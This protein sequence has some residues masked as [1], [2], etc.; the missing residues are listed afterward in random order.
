[1]HRCPLRLAPPEGVEMKTD[2]T[3]TVARADRHAQ[4]T[5]VPHPHDWSGRIPASRNDRT[6][7]LKRLALNDGGRLPD[8]D[9]AGRLVDEKELEGFLVPGDRHQRCVHGSD[10]AEVLDRREDYLLCL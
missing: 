6:Q 5:T 4:S 3:A 10:W 7:R 1:M 2:R 8:A 9:G